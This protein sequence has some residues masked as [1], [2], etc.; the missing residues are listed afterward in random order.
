MGALG[1]YNYDERHKE[2][3]ALKHMEMGFYIL[4][5][6]HTNMLR[7]SVGYVAATYWFAQMSLTL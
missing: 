5:T 7:E 1:N 4:K 2:L 6:Y 3:I